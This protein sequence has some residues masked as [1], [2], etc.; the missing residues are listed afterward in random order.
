[1]GYVGSEGLGGFQAA[2]GDIDGDDQSRIEELRAGDGGQPDWPRTDDSHY[3]TGLDLP[4]EDADLVCGGEDVGQH[5][6]L[7]VANA[8][9]DGVRREVGERD[10]DL[11]SLR[12]VDLV[13]E[14][15][16]AAT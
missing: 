11:L 9:G 8:F 10:P 13:A 3:V 4:V 14:D 6:N 1:D 16:A 7:L 12:P 5:Q 2:V 15:P